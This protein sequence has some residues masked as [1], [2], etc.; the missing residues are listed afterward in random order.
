[1]TAKWLERN[2]QQNTIT[3]KINHRDGTVVIPWFGQDQRFPTPRCG[4][5]MDEGWNQPL[6]SG[7]KTHLNTTMFCLLLLNPV[8]EESP[9]LGASRPYNLK[10]TKKYRA[11]EGLATH[12]RPKNQSVNTHTSRNK[13]SQHN[14]MSSQLH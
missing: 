11:R 9:Q 14:S 13:S 10:F 1:M 6:S 4:V 7:P 8:C 12:T 2:L 5:P 3:N